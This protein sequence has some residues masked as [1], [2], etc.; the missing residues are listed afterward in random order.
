MADRSLSS[1]AKFSP[2]LLVLVVLVV[3]QMALLAPSLP[4]SLACFRNPQQYL[5][6][7]GAVQA[8]STRLGPIRATF[9]SRF[10]QHSSELGKV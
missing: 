2:S 7:E 1:F 10:D 6:Q 9:L 4:R 8:A 3:P 5:Y